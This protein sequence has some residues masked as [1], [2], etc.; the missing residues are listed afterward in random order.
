MNKRKKIKMRNSL[1]PF[2]LLCFGAALFASTSNVK[3]YRKFSDFEKGESKGVA[4]LHDGVLTLAPAART[5]VEASVPHILAIATAKDEIFLAGGDPATLIKATPK[6]DT[7]LVYQSEEAVTIFA[8]CRDRSNAIWF[9]PSPG[10]EIYRYAGG[11]STKMATLDVTY[12]WSLLPVEGKIYAATGEPGMI[13]TITASGDTSRFFDSNET[14]IRT[15]AVDGRGNLYAGSA[16]HG[17][18]YR[19]DRNGKPFVVYDSPQTEVFAILPAA[20][21]ELWAAAASEGLRRPSPPA[22]T[23]S[24]SELSIE[25]EG[26]HPA[27]RP[28]SQQAAPAPRTR[29][30]GGK[31][32]LYKISSNGVARNFWE[33]QSERIQSIFLDADGSLW[34]GTGDS[35][36]IFRLAPEGKVDLLMDMEPAQ[37]T[38]FHGTKNSILVTTANSGSCV[39]IDRD[40]VQEGSYLSPV[41]DAEAQSRWGSISWKNTGHV[42]LYTRSGNSETPDRT[43]SDWQGPMKQAAG[44]AITSPAARFL[45][46]R[47]VLKK[48][49]RT[50]PTLQEILIGYKQENVAPEVTEISIY[51]PGT[52]YPDA[53]KKGKQGAD[54]E[55]LGRMSAGNSTRSNQRGKKEEKKGYQSI[56]W[57][58]RDHNKDRLVYTLYYQKTGTRAWRPL[59]QDYTATVYS[60]DTQTMED[61][62]YLIKVVASDR[63]SNPAGSAMQGE[64]VSEP[65]LVDNTA[66]EV[67]DLRFVARSPA[68]VTF[69]SEDAGSRITSAYFAVDAGEWQLIYPGDGIADSR[70]ERYAIPV[71]DL[72]AGEHTLTV[73]VFDEFQNVRVAHINFTR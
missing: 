62:R 63:L 13:Y 16:D 43:W 73:K 69:R 5:R 65:I 44:S 68:S 18:L 40:G 25:G 14:H 1:I 28:E 53:V 52:A 34:V 61:G 8:L 36:Q 30:R 21:G 10:G 50:L 49:G 46:W 51:P 71:S 70:V 64:K 48:Q 4:I 67:A 72:P 38:G 31:G 15:L 12:I 7:A 55:E 2:L 24:V 59:V 22:A 37:V 32:A 58:A 23:V 60:W 39:Q 9:A 56:G 27:P 35:G 29:A 20:D 19:F 6:G 47:A 41:F 66:P 45:Q 54:Q 33:N 57:H 26:E 42:E 17:L 11:R 3:Q